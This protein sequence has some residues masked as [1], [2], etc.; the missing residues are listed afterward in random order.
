[1]R[2]NVLNIIVISMRIPFLI[3]F[4]LF[5]GIS[6]AQESNLSFESDKWDFGK[7]AEEGGKVDYLFRF[8]N[9]LSYPVV[10]LDIKSG[11]GCTTPEY[12]RKPVKPGESG[13]VKIIFDPMNRPGHFTKSVMVTTSASNVPLRLTIQGEV[14][15]RQKSVE[16]QYP[17]DV[18]DGL[19]LEVNFHA[20]SYVGRGERVEERI[21]WINTSTRDI[22]LKFLPHQQ[23]GLCRVEYPE[24][25]PAGARGEIILIY[26]IN[27]ESNQYGTLNDI[28]DIE[29]NGTI[30]RTM[31]STQAIAVDKYDADIDEIS[32]PVARF[33]KN[34]IKF[35][36]VKRSTTVVNQELEILNDGEIDLIIRAV[37]LNDKSIQCSLKAGEKIRPGEKKRVRLILNTS[38][39]DYGVWV[40]RLRV[41][42]ND[43][44]HPMRTLRVTAVVVD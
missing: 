10:I 7:V 33:S 41:V 43:P 27:K 29:V 19:R 16:E 5:A 25:L 12:S 23:S 6:M 13:S 26:N 4:A 8:K 32:V 18:G 35:A 39:C 36:E 14:Q 1:M 21:G 24:R 3:I 40:D 28:F 20:F 37:E 34:F 22:A 30:V 44:R 15:P 17:F 11:C 9:N 38:E 2:V 42:T 31:L